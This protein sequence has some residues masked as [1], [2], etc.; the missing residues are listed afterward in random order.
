M[1]CDNDP[2]ARQ[3]PSP[4]YT[5]KG[6]SWTTVHMWNFMRA[7]RSRNVVIVVLGHNAALACHMANE[8]HFRKNSVT[9][10]AR[11]IKG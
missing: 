1:A 9:D 5:Y 7:V 10:A 8:S 3:G 6:D 2:R 11:P 4:G